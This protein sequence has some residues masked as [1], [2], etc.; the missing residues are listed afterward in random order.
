MQTKKRAMS[1]SYRVTLISVLLCIAFVQSCSLNTR[2]RSLDRIGH[3]Y[4]IQLEQRSTSSGTSSSGNSTSRMALT[5]RVVELRPDGI[6]LEFDLPGE[7]SE[8]DRAIEWQFPARVLKRPDGSLEL[9]NFDELEARSTEWLERAELDSSACGQWLFTWTAVKIEC[10]PLSAVDMIQPF[11]LRLAD[12]ADGAIYEEAGADGPSQ[13]TNTQLESGG[14]AFKAE[15]KINP[16]FVRRA[17]AESDIIVAEIMGETVPTLE[18]AIQSRSLERYSG[19]IVTEF[20]TD[21][22]GRVI[23]KTTV[24]QIR[25]EFPDQTVENETTTT[26][27]RRAMLADSSD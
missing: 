5:E 19:T 16:D 18:A 23:Q 6:V 1:V 17:R 21:P 27:V 22:L 20:R 26:T 10:D 15:M 8:E 13:L 25:S 24:V 12:L 11:D 9:T 7:V 3:T 4:K 14:S 2:E